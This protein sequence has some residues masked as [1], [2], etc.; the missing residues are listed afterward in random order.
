MRFKVYSC[1]AIGGFSKVYLG[2]SYDNGHFY[3]LKFIRKTEG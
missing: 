2:R 1:L 3:A